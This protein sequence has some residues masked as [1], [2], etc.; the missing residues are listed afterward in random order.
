[1]VRT[2]PLTIPK[3]SSV[4]NPAFIPIKAM[5]MDTSPITTMD[6]PANNDDLILNPEMNAPNE[7]ENILPIITAREKI[8]I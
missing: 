5:Y 4:N 6:K 2:H 8:I 1:M 3:K 7:T